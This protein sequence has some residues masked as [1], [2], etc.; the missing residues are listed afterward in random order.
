MNYEKS[1]PS[2]APEPTNEEKRYCEELA[3]TDEKIHYL[4]GEEV[5]IYA[6]G[7]PELRFEQ[8]SERMEANF[9]V[10]S[11]FARVEELLQKMDDT[12][13]KAT[14]KQKHMI[15]SDKAVLL[16]SSLQNKL[17]FRLHIS[18][19]PPVLKTSFPEHSM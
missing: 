15:F 17:C 18:R 11:V 12:T 10:R 5:R 7:G 9:F 6:D 13:I 16:G 1:T 2:D 4:N 14:A 8:W 3:H 19:I